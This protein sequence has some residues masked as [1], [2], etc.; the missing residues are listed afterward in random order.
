[1]EQRLFND[2]TIDGEW[3]GYAGTYDFYGKVNGKLTLLDWK[4]SSS[5]HDTYWMQL[6]AE[7]KAADFPVEQLGIVRMKPD[8]KTPRCEIKFKSVEELEPYWRSFKYR[9]LT[10]WDVRR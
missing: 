6:A 4:T 1:M 7:V 10:C 3:C 8:T 5:I 9:L 2:V